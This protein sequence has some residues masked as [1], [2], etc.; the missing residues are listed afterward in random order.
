MRS[1]G[2]IVGLLGGTHMAPGDWHYKRRGTFSSFP[3]GW[4][5]ARRDLLLQWHVSLNSCVWLT[6]SPQSTGVSKEVKSLK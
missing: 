4:T 5:G 6:D 2:P 3:A 1:E